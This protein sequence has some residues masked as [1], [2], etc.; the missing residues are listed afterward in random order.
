MPSVVAVTYHLLSVLQL[1]SEPWA[2]QEVM[3]RPPL[4]APVLLCP[5]QWS[6]GE[7]RIL[8]RGGGTCLA[9][10]PA[11]LSCPHHFPRLQIRFHSSSASQMGSQSGIPF[12]E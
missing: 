12:F 1:G 4:P 6:S 7:N 3:L 9:L 2:F 10:G 5:L 11:S 8:S